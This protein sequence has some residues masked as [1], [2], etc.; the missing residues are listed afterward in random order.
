MR[1]LATRI[2]SS[3]L[4]WRVFGDRGSLGR[5]D[6]SQ[7]SESRSG[8]GRVSGRICFRGW[9]RRLIQMNIANLA[10]VPRSFMESWA[11]PYSYAFGIKRWLW[12]SLLAGVLTPAC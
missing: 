11:W 12:T 2:Q 5:W 6:W 1:T 8:R 4:S 9:L 3:D 10:G 7:R